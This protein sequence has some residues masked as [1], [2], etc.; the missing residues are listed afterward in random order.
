MGVEKLKNLVKGV[1]EHLN[2]TTYV[3]ILIGA[4][5][6][7]AR[8]S[9]NTPQPGTGVTFGPEQVQTALVNAKLG[10]TSPQ[11]ALA[12]YNLVNNPSTTR[13]QLITALKKAREDHGPERIEQAADEMLAKARPLQAA[14]KVRE[15]KS[16]KCLAGG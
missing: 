10:R 2:L 16:L 9:G 7:R 4:A 1:F 6:R 11:V 13:D 12:L 3:S 14:A 15:R 8:S 5:I